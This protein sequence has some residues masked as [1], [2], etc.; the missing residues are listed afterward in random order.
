MVCDAQSQKNDMEIRF[1]SERLR[2]AHAHRIER[3]VHHPDVHPLNISLAQSRRTKVARQELQKPKMRRNEIVNLLL[4]FG[5]RLFIRCS[6]LLLA[7]ERI[8]VS[9]RC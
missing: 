6:K 1:T 3:D 8:F 2:T 5:E 7:V 9:S 4:A